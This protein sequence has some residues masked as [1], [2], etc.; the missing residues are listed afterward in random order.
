M[1]LPVAKRNHRPSDWRCNSPTSWVQQSPEQGPGS[2][3]ALATERK[4][5]LKMSM[6]EAM[7][8]IGEGGGR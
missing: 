7:V 8:M 5:R 3:K 2:E 1:P 6:T 4:R